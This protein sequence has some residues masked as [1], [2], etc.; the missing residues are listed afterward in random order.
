MKNSKKL[1][2]LLITSLLVLTTLITAFSFTACNAIDSAEESLNVTGTDV[3]KTGDCTVTITSSVPTDPEE[4][5]AIFKSSISVKDISLSE[6]LKGKTVTAVKFI[7]Q[8]EIEVSLSGN[9]KDFSGDSD[10]GCI[11]ISK[12]AL[13]NDYGSCCVVSV[14]KSNISVTALHS[15][16]HLGVTAY[17]ISFGL[18]NG[19]FTDKATADNIKLAA[20]SEGTLSN[21][22]LKNNNTVLT[23]CVDNY[24]P[25]NPPTV[26]MA[27]SV[28]TFNVSISMVMTASARFVFE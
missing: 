25:K 20:G 15:T 1:L 28:T 23:L 13:E 24:N 2:K 10:V 6:A 11:H 18:S 17:E 9:A 19:S 12:N 7:S 21:I 27:P 8:T 4:L 14:F 26:E 16:T 3:R 5:P 22:T